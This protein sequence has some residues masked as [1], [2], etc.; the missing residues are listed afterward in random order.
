[1]AGSP[2]DIGHLALGRRGERSALWALRRRGYRILARN[3]RTKLGEIDIVARHRGTLVFVEVKTRRSADL[4]PAEESVGP[5][6][7]RHIHR[8]AQLYLQEK[9]LP[10]DTDCRIDVVSVTLP[11]RWWS[12][13]RIEIF[14]DAFEVRAWR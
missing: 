12:R 10:D 1:M 13:P 6:K 9:G 11:D 2:K 8:V 14:E 3:Y 7:Q 4:V 5:R